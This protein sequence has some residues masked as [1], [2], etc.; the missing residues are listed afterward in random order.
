[1]GQ[2]NEDLENI[3]LSSKM[4]KIAV[5]IVATLALAQQSY[6][7]SKCYLGTQNSKGESSLTETACSTD[8]VKAHTAFSVGDEDAWKADMIC[9]PSA[10]FCAAQKDECKSEAT[11]L[12]KVTACCCS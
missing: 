1:M 6:G 2:S 4:L 12:G 5:Y 9:A 8:C 11:A 10:A 3:S 7:L